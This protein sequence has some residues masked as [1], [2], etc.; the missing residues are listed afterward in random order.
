MQYFI[1]EL[2]YCG[3]IDWPDFRNGL[4]LPEVD[5]ALHIHDNYA[6]IECVSN[7]KNTHFI[8]HTNLATVDLAIFSDSNI[9]VC[10]AASLA[11]DDPVFCFLS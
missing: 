1:F 11:N 2:L 9:L 5:I 6:K 10:V 4:N 7:K 3:M 8:Y